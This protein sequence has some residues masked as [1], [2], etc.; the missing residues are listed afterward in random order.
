M[1]SPLCV[2]SH[3]FKA[4]QNRGFLF[5]YLEDVAL[6]KLEALRLPDKY[7]PLDK[8]IRRATSSR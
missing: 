8:Y 7:I 5:T 1:G 4:E 6:L 2:F 3:L